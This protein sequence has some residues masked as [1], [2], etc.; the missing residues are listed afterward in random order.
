MV[1]LE[2]ADYTAFTSGSIY[3]IN[4]EIDVHYHS[5]DHVRLLVL[6]QGGIVRFM[7]IDVNMLGY[8]D[9]VREEP[10]LLAIKEKASDTFDL[11]LFTCTPDSTAHLT[12]RCRCF[13]A[14]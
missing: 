13:S 9:A 11:S 14:V 2:P 5:G 8:K 1:L 3:S 7:D 12:V 10:D 6:T 4:T